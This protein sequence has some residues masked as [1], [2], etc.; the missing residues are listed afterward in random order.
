MRACK[1][2]DDFDVSESHVTRR[3]IMVTGHVGRARPWFE[4]GA[5][6]VLQSSTIIV[7]SIVMMIIVDRK[8]NRM[9]RANSTSWTGTALLTPPPTDVM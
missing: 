4:A 2:L 8:D 1:N 9:S 7:P 5:D 3:S 6:D